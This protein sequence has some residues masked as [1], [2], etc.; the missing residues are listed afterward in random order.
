MPDS[1]GSTG[2]VDAIALLRAQHR[3]VEELFGRLERLQPAA[4]GSAQSYLTE[5]RELVDQVV[6][7][8]MRHS[9][10]EEACFYP[11]VAEH[12][13]RGG[14]LVGTAVRQH[15]EAEAVTNRI[16]RMSPDNVDFDAGLRELI[17]D[18]RQH[19]LMEET[20]IFPAIEAALSRE[21][22]LE[23]GAQLERAMRTVPTRP[24]P[25]APP[26]T[27]GVGKLLAKG[28]AVLDRMRDVAGGRQR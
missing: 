15:K 7:R 4:Q 10:I 8:L 24:H 17:A 5:R 19:V 23:L 27:T 12:A 21:Q 18:V 25:H 6:N 2:P 11:A 3:E 1:Q 20:E 22:L 28:V 13:A 26:A 16:D 9:N 14:A